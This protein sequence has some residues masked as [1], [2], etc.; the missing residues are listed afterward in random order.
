M[1]PSDYKR[2]YRFKTDRTKER[3]YVNISIALTIILA[4]LWFI[5]D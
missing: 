4:L 2:N 1:L 3:K 5:F